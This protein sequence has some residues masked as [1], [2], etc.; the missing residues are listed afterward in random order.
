MGT[1]HVNTDAMRQLGNLF[2]QLNE[3][4]ATQLEPQIQHYTAMLETDWIG[5]SRERFE[6]ALN[7]WRGPPTALPPTVKKSASTCNKPLFVSRAPTN[8]SNYP[9][10]IN[11][12][13]DLQFPACSLGIEV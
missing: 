6:S 9:S 7:E 12:W 8:L 4:I 13:S 5:V 2:A 10:R 11:R 3:Q 1:I